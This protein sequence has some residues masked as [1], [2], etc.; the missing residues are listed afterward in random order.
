MYK[1]AA[2]RPESGGGDP[3]GPQGGKACARHRHPGDAENLYGRDEAGVLGT[4][5]RGGL[6]GIQDVYK[7]QMRSRD[8]ALLGEAKPGTAWPPCCTENAPSVRMVR[9]ERPVKADAIG[10]TS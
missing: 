3:K 4:V 7:R 5:Y 8:A 9:Q 6:R 1:R 2:E 10:N